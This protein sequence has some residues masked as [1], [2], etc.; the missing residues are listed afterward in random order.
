MFCFHC[1]ADC[2]YTSA[3]IS[4]FLRVAATLAAPPGKVVLI[5]AAVNNSQTLIKHLW[6]RTILFIIFEAELCGKVHL[7]L[8]AVLCVAFLSQIVLKMVMAFKTVSNE[9]IWRNSCIFNKN[10]ILGL[11]NMQYHQRP[12]HFNYIILRLI[13]V[14]RL[15]TSTW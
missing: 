9:W 10:M 7:Q 8:F 14:Y 13:L 11:I 12:H 1:F 15:G 4:A 3:Y 6:P 5:C 2:R